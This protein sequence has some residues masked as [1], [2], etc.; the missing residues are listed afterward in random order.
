[1]DLAAISKIQICPHM[2]TLVR[3]AVPRVSL[4]R[5]HYLMLCNTVRSG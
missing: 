3:H 1:M 2:P 4:A 5:D